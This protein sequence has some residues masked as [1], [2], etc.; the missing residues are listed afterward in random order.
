LAG[1]LWYRH[2]DALA[3]VGAG[4]IAVAKQGFAAAVLLAVA[5]AGAGLDCIAW[6]VV[7]VVPAVLALR[8]G[9]PDLEVPAAAF[10][11]V[12][13]IAACAGVQEK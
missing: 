10:Q 12:H 8:D 4:S 1:N 7:V 13:R 6:L 3:E 9:V 5:A 11:V 2:F